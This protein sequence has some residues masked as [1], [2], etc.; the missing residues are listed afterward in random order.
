MAG[1]CILRLLAGGIM[2][3][4]SGPGFEVKVKA[5][6]ALGTR[7]LRAGEKRRTFHPFPAQTLKFDALPTMP[8]LENRSNL[9]L[10]AAPT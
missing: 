1:C 8:L 7:R 2:E 9:R 5:D 6:I 10:P 4:Y 3:A